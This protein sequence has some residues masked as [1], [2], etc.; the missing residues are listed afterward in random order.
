VFGSGWW[1][2]YG[3]DLS[4]RLTCSLV[5][6]LSA[7]RVEWETPLDVGVVS[8]EDALYAVGF[9]RVLGLCGLDVVGVVFVRGWAPRSLTFYGRVFGLI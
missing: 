4:G 6:V 3:G 7:C 2:T 5:A 9:G 1:Y 8:C